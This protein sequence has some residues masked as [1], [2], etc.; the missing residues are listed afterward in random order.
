M[1]RKTLSFLLLISCV[2]LMCAAVLTMRPFA[3]WADEGEETTAEETA[4]DS[5]ASDGTEDLSSEELQ[6]QLDAANE[7]LSQLNEQL[8]ATGEELNGL[9]VEIDGTQADIDELTPRIEELET[10]VKSLEKQISKLEKEIEETQQKIDDNQEWI[11]EDTSETYK[12]GAN[13]D[14]QMLFSSDSF[15]EYEKRKYYADKV[16]SQRADTI[17][18]TKELQDDL[19]AKR[20]KL[21]AQN[22]ELTKQKSELDE[23]KAVLDAKQAEQKQLQNDL[24]ARQADYQRQSEEQQAYVESLDQKVQEKL[25]EERQARLEA[26]RQAALAGANYIYTGAAGGELTNDERSIIVSAAYEQL[27]LPYEWGGCEPG[28]AFDCSGLALWCYQQVGYSLPH[29]SGA[30]A[31]MTDLK[32]LEELLPGDLCF[33]APGG[34]VSH[35]AIYIGDGKVIE[36]ADTPLDVHDYDYVSGFIGGGV[37]SA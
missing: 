25:E 13:A 29:Y 7:Q 16:E 6:A 10:K 3:A 8:A 1:R 28:V 19:K 37:P 21:D 34:T 27:G 26:A 5:S 12:N 30:Q 11:S 18:E 20:A 32:P 14:L 4:G 22:E 31:A 23:Q 15:E 17:Q 9:Q 33:Y 24:T 35:V 36:A 2:L